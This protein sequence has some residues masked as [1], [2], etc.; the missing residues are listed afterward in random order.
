MYVQYGVYYRAYL[1]PMSPCGRLC[2]QL[3]MNV[4]LYMVISKV[5]HCVYVYVICVQI[6]IFAQVYMLL[7]ALVVWHRERQLLGKT[8]TNKTVFLKEKILKKPIFALGFAITSI[9]HD[10][11]LFCNVNVISVVQNVGDFW[12]CRNSH[13]VSW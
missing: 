12:Y 11:H 10:L 4:C 6:N 2:M 7:I 3:D 13:F 8:N 9:H 5:T 1:N